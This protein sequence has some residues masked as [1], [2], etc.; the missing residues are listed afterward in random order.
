MTDDKMTVEKAREIVKHPFSDSVVRLH[1]ENDPLFGDM[2]LYAHAKGYLEAIEQTKP[3]VEALKPFSKNYEF[4]VT[5]DLDFSLEEKRA[6]E[7]L[8]AYKKTVMGEEG[9]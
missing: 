5:N 8:S 4:A 6:F 3:L 1:T 9:R 7:A 2:I